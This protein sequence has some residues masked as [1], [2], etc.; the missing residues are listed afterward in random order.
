[1][2]I[3]SINY[4]AHMID[5]DAF[6]MG[7]DDVTFDAAFITGAFTPDVHGSALDDIAV[8]DNTN[9]GVFLNA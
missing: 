2:R 1:M 4:V 8:F 7:D 5:N 3:A 6:P 9:M